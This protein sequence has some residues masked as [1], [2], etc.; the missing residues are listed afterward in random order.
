METAATYNKGTEGEGSKELL[1]NDDG[2]LLVG[3]D[4][5]KLEA[6]FDKRYS[7]L[8]GSSILTHEEYINH[9]DF[10]IDSGF[11]AFRLL[12]PFD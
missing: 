2:Y 12:Q 7:I 8:D 6:E 3:S 1:V 5:R 9:R 4:K 11:F 10:L